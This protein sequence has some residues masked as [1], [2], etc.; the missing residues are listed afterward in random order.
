MGR[1]D[2]LRRDA[3]GLQLAR[4]LEDGAPVADEMLVID[5][6]SAAARAKTWILSS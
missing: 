3:L 1:V 5:E 2:P 6:P 4:L